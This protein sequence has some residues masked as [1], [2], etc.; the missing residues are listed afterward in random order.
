MSGSDVTVTQISTCREEEV[1]KGKVT[2]AFFTGKGG[3]G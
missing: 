3:V 2:A 1:I